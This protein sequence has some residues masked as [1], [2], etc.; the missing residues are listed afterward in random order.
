MAY[1]GT[2]GYTVFKSQLTPAQI[3]IIHR[4]LTVRPNL[5]RDMGV[6]PTYPIYR[7]SEKKLYLPRYYGIEHYGA[8]TIKLSPG[9]NVDLPFHGDLFDYQRVIIDKFIRHVGPVAGGGLLDVEPGKGK[10]VMALNIISR[11]GRKTLV[12]VHKTFLMNQWMERIEHF[13]PGA[14]VGRIQGEVIDVEG[15]DIVLGMLQSVSNKT[16]PDSLWA[17]FGLTVFDECHHLAAEV[18]SNVMVAV[19][20][21]YTLGLSGT[22]VRKDG[23]TKVFKYFIG[24]VVH[25]EKSDVSTHQVVVKSVRYHQHGLFDDV[26]TDYR[27]NPMYS[28]LVSK[29]NC[30]N[31]NHLIAEVVRH[32]LA[33]NPNQQIMILSHTK[34]MI[35]KLHDM[36]QTFEPSIGFYLGGMKEAN[37]KDSESKKVILGTYQ[38]ASEGL[39]IKTLTT[40]VL[41][42]PKSDVCQSV[43]RILRSRHENPLVI[44]VVDNHFFF[45]SQYRK[46]ATY[47]N[48]KRYKIMDYADLTAYLGQV[49]GIAAAEEVNLESPFDCVSV[50]GHPCFVALDDYE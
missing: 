9:M 46:R 20:T 13:L 44:D 4:D 21:P 3:D 27:G 41:A 17:Q 36:I 2:R 14:K 30:P 7:E 48:S 25:K 37:L 31:R 22:M 32:E 26:R 16:Y 34:D 45:E 5:G 24:P 1:L 10:T 33:L 39:D 8:P 19:V 42:T 47:Y 12:V 35:Y 29:L 23:L 28:V 15:K 6:A 43:G 18:F 38:M 11:L 40:L 50:D 49:E